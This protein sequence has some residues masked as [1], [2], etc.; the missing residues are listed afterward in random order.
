M[1]FDNRRMTTPLLWDVFCRVI[2]NHGDLGVCWRLSRDLATRGHRVRL[3][4]DDDRALAWMAPHGHPAVNCLRWTPAPADGFTGPVAPAGV[5]DH[6]EPGDVV[7]EAFGCDPPAAYVARM[8]RPVPPVWINLE[9]LSAEA[10][11]ERSHGLRSPQMSGPGAGLDKWFFFPG[12]SASTGGLLREPDL[13]ARRDAF[14]ACAWLA[15][16]GLSEAATDGARR[17]SLFC[18][19]N[20]RVPALL[21][22]LQASTSPVHLLATPGPATE[23]VQAVLGTQPRHG[24][25]TDRKSVV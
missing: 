25:L 21:Q 22:A 23:Q 8:Q 20:D 1:R 9:Y 10:W 14:D 24:A 19:A 16:R 11:V 15:D 3:W 17:V 6:T 5:A 4:I 7:I 2:D 13:I 12:F 18:Y